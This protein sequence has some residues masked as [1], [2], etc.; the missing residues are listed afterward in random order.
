MS[1]V[2]DIKPLFGKNPLIRPGI[3]YN[4][5]DCDLRQVPCEFIR[6]PNM[7][8]VY[9]TYKNDELFFTNKKELFIM[10]S[11]WNLEKT[12]GQ[13]N[14]ISKKKNIYLIKKKNTIIF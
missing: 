9:I 14:K 2:V 3:K 8:Y 6:L 12:Y 7:E 13:R 11:F 1:L 10:N 5:I 4:K